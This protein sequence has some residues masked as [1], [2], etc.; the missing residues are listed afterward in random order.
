M[1]QLNEV[2]IETMCRL[3]A[4]YSKRPWDGEYL[5]VL[6]TQPHARREARRGGPR[7]SVPERHQGRTQGPFV[8]RMPT[9]ASRP[10][11]A[12]TLTQL[13]AVCA[14]RPQTERR[15]PR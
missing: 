14:S 12:P 1:L 4:K 10:P 2:R 3:Y 6:D 7:P 13:A 9:P 15:W 8:A 5:D 11:A